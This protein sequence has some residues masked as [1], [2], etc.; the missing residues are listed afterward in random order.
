MAIESD[1]LNGT[2][3]ASR[4]IGAT[5]STQQLTATLSAGT[6]GPP[7]PQ[8]PAG[9]TGPVGPAGPPGPQGE[10][11]QGIEIQ[12]SVPSSGDLPLT[13]APGDAWITSDTGHMWVWD[14][15]TSTWTDAG[16]VQGP[17]GPAGPQGPQGIQG[18]A[19]QQG[20]QGPAG[21]TGPIGPA[22]PAGPTGDTGAQGPQGAQGIQGIQ[23]P[24]GPAGSQGAIGPAGPTG[25]TG[26]AGPQGEPG[27]DSTVPGPPGPTGPAGP[28]GDPGP[29]GPQGPPMSVQD[30][31]S[32]I[33]ALPALN[34]IG[35]GVTATAD[36]PNNR[37]NVTIPGAA[38]DA[39]A[40]VFG[41]T[42]T[43]VAQS[44]DY[45]AAQVTNAVSTA[46]SYADPAWLTSINVSRVTVTG[47]NTAGT[48]AVT[49]LLLDRPYGD[50]GDSMDIVWSGMARISLNAIGTGEKGIIFYAQT[51]SGNGETNEVMRVQ[52]N[53]VVTMNR[54][55]F[56]DPNWRLQMECGPNLH[57]FIGNRAGASCC[58]QA[59]DFGVTTNQP[60][61]FLASQLI[62]EAPVY[63]MFFSGVYKT[64]S[65]DASGFVKAT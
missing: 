1:R 22:G 15:D 40:S 63:K 17:P 12:G 25:A 2:I 23:G 50:I 38:A 51:G 8:G 59:L 65:V 45:T 10:P 49:G 35:A 27:A 56:A 28:E 48:N 13:G 46:G 47:I 14:E 62:F 64:L 21:A 36:S 42:G 16:L 58:L 24:A 9:P 26:P 3:G 19:G 29:A 34:F 60:L 53:K 52:G 41:R 32:A 57:L 30:E 18:A 4:D 37:I 61:E 55:A 44:G 6:P 7:G 5:V 54:P 31:G 11:G 33:A 20:A 43:V 39:V